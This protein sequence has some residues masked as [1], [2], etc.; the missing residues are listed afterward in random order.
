M[1]K[2][3]VTA[4]H[5][6][7]A[8]VH[9]QKLVNLIQSFPASHRTYSVFADFVEQLAGESMRQRRD[10]YPHD[11]VLRPC[12]TAETSAKPLSFSVFRDLESRPPRTTFRIGK[13]RPL[14]AI[15][16]AKK[17]SI[18]IVPLVMAKAVP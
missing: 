9:Q 16:T 2:K 13:S 12:A 18:S 17:R 14:R 4:G 5:P 6:V 1:S 15:L 10:G 8:D 11:S 7:A 3:R